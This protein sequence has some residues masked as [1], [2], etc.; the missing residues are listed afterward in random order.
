MKKFVSL[1]ILL[2]VLTACNLQ[3]PQPTVAED[4]LPTPVHPSISPE[5]SVDLQISP[6]FGIGT[7]SQLVWS[8]DGTLLATGGSTGI[9]FYTAYTLEKIRYIPT[10]YLITSVAFSPDG[11]TLASGSADLVFSSRSSWRR[12]SPFVS[13]NNFVQLWDVE[14]GNLLATL[15]AGFSYV[16]SV[17]FSPDGT[18][19]ASGSM[20]PNDNA[21]RI[22]KLDAVFQGDNRPWQLHK[23]HSYGIFGIDFSPD[24]TVLLSGSGDNSARLWDIPGDRMA[25]ILN[26]WSES[27][28]QVFAVEYSPVTGQDG[29]QLV[30]LAG[31]ELLHSTP[32]AMLEVWDVASSAPLPKQHH[33]QTLILYHA[34]NET[35]HNSKTVDISDHNVQ[36]PP[37]DFLKSGKLVFELDGH[38]SSIDSVAY[39]PDG[40]LLASG[41]S[42]PDNKINIWDM[43]SGELLRVI[44][45]HASGVRNVA[46]SPNGKTLASSGWDGLLKLWD[47]KSGRLIRSNNEHTSVIHCAA[48]SP[49]GRI[50]ATGG[51]EG[52]I[53]L[54]DV[55]TGQR[56][57]TLNAH[58]SRVT[59]LEFT[60]DGTKLI[61]GTDEPDYNLQVWDI[62]S[63]AL[64][65]SSTGH[66]NFIQVMALSPDENMLAS[67]GALGDNSVRIWNLSADS[68]AVDIIE[69]HTRSVKSLAF[70]TDS[71]LIASG[72]GT[73]KIRLI[74]PAT[75]QVMQIIEG[76]DCAINTLA[77]DHA[78]GNLI[79]GGC[80]GIVRIWDIESGEMLQELIGPD[81]T[82]IQLVYEPKS[83]ELVVGYADNS[84][85]LWNPMAE[86]PSV[87]V[88]GSQSGIQSIR[89]NM[90]KVLLAMDSSDGVLR[91]W[92]LER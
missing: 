48:I 31:A 36:H 78:N 25:G 62:N 80:N 13:E 10:S 85:W 82:V 55:E 66:N 21:I 84:I 65:K 52:F 81:E 79:S 35:R 47:V 49:D 69:G 54:W 15:E 59:S 24:G 89:M 90:G 14:S 17:A 1:Y 2:L 68:S 60:P 8:P 11:S 16:T 45:G 74:D 33:A 40:T 34:D 29:E 5:N 7:I 41:G 87:K 70:S 46:F 64:L 26:Y 86:G 12:S 3:L 57:N 23:E 30:A 28:V 92:T 22:W 4:N 56:L 58:S 43:Q 37:R 72:D 39:N 88:E 71:Q 38:D 50:V 73:G 91:F 53:R 9:R 77:F 18:L 20:Y 42:Y 75:G 32:T 19:V 51:D 27:N 44:E 83:Q 6:P 61:A 76:Q 63:S 67:G